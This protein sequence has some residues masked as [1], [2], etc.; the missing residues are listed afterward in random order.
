[1]W[2][3]V[4]YF[5]VGAVVGAFITLIWVDH[6]LRKIMSIIRLKGL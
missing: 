6:N 4:A 2:I 3:K 5:G 1:M